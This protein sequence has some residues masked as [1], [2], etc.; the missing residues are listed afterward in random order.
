M[1]LSQFNTPTVWG[2][3]ALLAFLAVVWMPELGKL[4]AFLP[5]IGKAAPADDDVADLT[6]AKRLAARFDKAGCKEGQAAVK[7][8][9]EHFFHTGA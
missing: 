6:A 9:L 2:I 7:V 8:C 1:D 5:A 3:G 4:T